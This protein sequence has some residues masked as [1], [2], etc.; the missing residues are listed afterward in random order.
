MFCAAVL[1]YDGIIQADWGLNHIVA[2][3]AG[4]DV[5]GGMG[6]RDVTR[7]GGSG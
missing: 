2:M 1:G 7:H 6:Q 4:A 5:M 3:Q